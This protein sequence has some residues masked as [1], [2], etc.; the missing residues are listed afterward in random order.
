[1]ISNTNE[2]KATEKTINKI[3][4]NST[5]R[6]HNASKKNSLTTD[7]NVAAALND[8]SPFTNVLVLLMELLFADF[9]NN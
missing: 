3:T 2:I 1:M 4:M 6:Q 8:S 7:T 9:T 5:V